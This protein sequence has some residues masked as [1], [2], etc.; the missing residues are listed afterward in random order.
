VLQE[1]KIVSGDIMTSILAPLEVFRRFVWNFFRLENEHLNNCG[2]FRAVRDISIAPIDSSDQTTILRMMDEEEG[3]INRWEWVCHLVSNG[4]S[5]FVPITQIHQT[6]S[7]QTEESKRHRKEA[8]YPADQVVAAGPVH[9]HVDA[10]AILIPDSH[11]DLCTLLL[12]FKSL[13]R[14]LKCGGEKGKSQLMSIYFFIQWLPLELRLHALVL[15]NSETL[16]CLTIWKCFNWL[17]ESVKR[18]VLIGL[19]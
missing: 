16:W 11:A 6:E 9:R 18:A 2:K 4:N 8:A 3:V 13:Q 19:R 15:R 5:N 14:Q 17:R 7:A 10:Q 1:K 12:S